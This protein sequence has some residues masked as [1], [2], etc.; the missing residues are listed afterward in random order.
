MSS[1][2]GLQ[3]PTGFDVASYDRVNEAAAVVANPNDAAAPWKQTSWFGYSAAWNGLALRLR[4]ATEYDAEFGRLIAISTA[5]DQEVRYVQE[6]ALFGCIASSFSA[7]ECFYM[8]TYCLGAA[9]SQSHFPLKDGEDLNKSPSQVVKSFQAWQ[10]SDPFSQVLATE[11]SSNEF[12]ILK[13]LRNS[14]AHRG[15][16]PR[17][18]FLSTDSDIP[19]AIP[20]NPKALAR[21]FAYDATLSASTTSAHVQW[22]NETTSRLVSALQ[23]FL[24]RYRQ[25]NDA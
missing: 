24:K 9:L 25:A 8:A 2:T 20:S 6:R 3:L 16:L 7:V 17:Q 15:I 10:R 23:D 11:A 4:S 13:D 14:L 19:S 21:N 1:T 5:P 22:V 12:K 18:V